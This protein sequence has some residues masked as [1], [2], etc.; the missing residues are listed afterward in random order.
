MVLYESRAVMASAAALVVPGESG[1]LAD[2][3]QDLC[4]VLL[5]RSRALPR[6]NVSGKIP[7]LPL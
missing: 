5:A 6:K 3:P 7:P 2:D 1:R 4:P